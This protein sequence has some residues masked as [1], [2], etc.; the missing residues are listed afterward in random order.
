MQHHRLHM[1]LKLFTR[2]SF[3]R[4]FESDSDY[5]FEAIAIIYD[6][7]KKREM[8]FLL[9][10]MYENLFINHLENFYSQN[11]DTETNVEPVG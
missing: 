6:I 4:W 9:V 10:Y 1:K 5:E 3:P 2:R 11:T 8:L 7:R